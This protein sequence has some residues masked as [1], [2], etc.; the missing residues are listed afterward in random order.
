MAT[1][2]R[3]FPNVQAVW[4][5]G[6]TRTRTEVA[7][8]LERFTTGPLTVSTDVM[9][10]VEFTLADFKIEPEKFLVLIQESPWQVDMQS[11]EEFHKDYRRVPP[12]P[13]LT[14]ARDCRLKRLADEIG[15]R[16]RLT[17]QGSWHD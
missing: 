12:R 1:Y 11:W 16:V 14:S 4:F 5:D 2:E 10:N 3:Y 7:E 8:F 17:E 13:P 9:G 6:T 15:N